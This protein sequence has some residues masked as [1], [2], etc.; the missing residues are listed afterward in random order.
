MRGDLLQIHISPP[1]CSLAQINS[2]SYL[3]KFLTLSANLDRFLALE[4]LDF[5]AHMCSVDAGGF[6][7]NV[8]QISD[9]DRLVLLVNN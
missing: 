8:L 6:I 9:A 5:S 2:Q 7:S 3:L 1:T 4:K